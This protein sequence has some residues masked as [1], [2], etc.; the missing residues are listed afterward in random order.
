MHEVVL[1]SPF[2]L[3]S[4][5]LEVQ[6][7][8]NIAF[9]VEQVGFENVTQAFDVT[10]RRLQSSVLTGAFEAMLVGIA[11]NHSVDLLG[12]STSRVLLYYAIILYYYIIL[13]YYHTIILSY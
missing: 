12:T 11:K 1:G 8:Y 4:T 3:L 7:D 13:L 9:I 6:V 2:Q 10:S 5:P